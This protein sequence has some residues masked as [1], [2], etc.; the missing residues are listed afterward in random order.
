M[1][2]Y[3]YDASVVTEWVAT[4]CIR[5]EPQWLWGWRVMVEE[6]RLIGGKYLLHAT[7]GPRPEYRWRPATSRDELAGTKFWRAA[8]A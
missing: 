5:I 2:I 1:N 7:A 8:D 6:R 3:E 4:G